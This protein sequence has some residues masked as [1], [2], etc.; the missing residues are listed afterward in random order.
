M[1]T[2]ELKKQRRVSPRNWLDTVSFILLLTLM[3]F[4]LIDYSLRRVLEIPIISSLWDEGVL[5][6]GLILT[7]ARWYQDK[8]RKPS[9]LVNK[10][11]LLYFLLGIGML[12]IDLST[13]AI[14]IEGFRAIYQYILFFYVGFYLAGKY[15]ETRLLISVAFILGT[16]IGLYGIYQYIVGVPMPSRWVDSGEAVK[17]R[18]YSII[19]S[20][21]ALGSHMAFLAPIGLGLLMGAKKWSHRALWILCTA[22]ILFCLL[23]TLSRGAWLAL[24]GA[25]GIMGIFYDKR[26]LAVGLIAAILAGIFIPAVNQRMGYLFS[27]EYM[28]KSSQSGRISR[29]LT[30]YDQMMLD[31]LLGV[32]L[33]HFGGAVAKRHYNSISVDNYY[34]GMLAETGLLGLGL[35][36]WL[37]FVV[38]KK[39]FKAWKSL[40]DPGPRHLAASLLAGLLVIALH[41]AVEN[42]FEIPYLTTYFWVMAGFLL[43]LPHSS[44]EGRVTDDDE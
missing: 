11:I 36:L 42:I 6:A 2:L 35:L 9:N 26:I 27:A 22:V 43:A 33:G 25:L 34:M 19:G 16:L 23:F 28:E 29:W 30:A 14:N 39:G 7:F 8:N 31:P 21:N 13:I 24:V 15:P 1:S 17:T 5:A 32:G 38:I 10:A 4:P 37:I 41:N 20:P 44:V 40:K 3:A 18:A 12:V